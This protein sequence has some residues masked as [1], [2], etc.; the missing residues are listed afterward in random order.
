[1]AH[2]EKLIDTRVKRM[3]KEKMTGINMVL[4]NKINIVL[5]EL[6]ADNSRAHHH[7]LSSAR[8]EIKRLNKEVDE[9]RQLL[10]IATTN[11]ELKCKHNNYTTT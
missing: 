8:D 11:E 5:H 7:V 9:L 3:K 2:L 6:K 4:D 1:M 10:T